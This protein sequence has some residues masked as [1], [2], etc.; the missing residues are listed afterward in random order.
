MTTLITGA[1]MIGSLAAARIVA[2]RGERP[3]LYD[4]AFSERNLRE[5]LDDGSVE[6]VK[7]TSVIS[8]TCCESSRGTTWI[9]S[10]TRRR[11]S[12]GI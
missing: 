4:I 5:R 12:P 7:G 8:A 2:E 9:A 10:S 1:G 3:V 11:C 6:F